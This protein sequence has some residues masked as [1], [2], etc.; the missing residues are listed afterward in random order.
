MTPDAILDTTF[1]KPDV[2]G[3]YTRLAPI[4]DVWAVLTE[5]RARR[6]CL[7]RAAITDGEAV[8]EVAVGTGLLFR[9]ILRVNRGGRNVGIDL[10][11]AMLARAR[12]KAA[13][14]GRPGSYELSVGDAYALGFPDGS[15]DV[16][17]NNYMFDLLPERDFAQVLGEFHRVLRPGGR[18]VMV[19]MTHGR[20]VFADVAEWV[21]RKKPALMGGCR[22]V[23]V[24]PAVRTSGFADVRR[25][26]VTQLGYA[27]EV[28]TAKRE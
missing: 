11:E 12:E 8:L 17:V 5:S 23:A 7:E 18:L 3:A 15:F 14:H 21:F 2:R 10:T 24:E 1:G 16:L 6:I 20:G 27:S 4:Y 22:S 28:L 26:L 9:D 25:E 19:N 13:R